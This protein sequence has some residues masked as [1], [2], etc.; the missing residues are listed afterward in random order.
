VRRLFLSTSAGL[1]SAALAKWSFS[2]LCSLARSR[3]RSCRALRKNGLS[4]WSDALTITVR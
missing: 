3:S 2:V 1:F 4:N